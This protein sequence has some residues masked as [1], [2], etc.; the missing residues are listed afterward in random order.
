MAGKEGVPEE[1]AVGAVT[2]TEI[3]FEYLTLLLEL[4]LAA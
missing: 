1:T 3:E 2:E 4:V